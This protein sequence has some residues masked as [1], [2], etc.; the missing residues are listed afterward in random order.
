MTGSF[1]GFE[2]CRAALRLTP[3]NILASEL[4][5]T[6]TGPVELQAFQNGADF[7]SQQVAVIG[8]MDAILTEKNK[9]IGGLRTRVTVAQFKNQA[10]ELAVASGVFRLGFA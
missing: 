5:P 8:W 3:R 10:F 4:M 6:K 9:L 7:E 2:N 1:L